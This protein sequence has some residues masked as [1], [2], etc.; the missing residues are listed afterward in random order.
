MNNSD[1]EINESSIERLRKRIII[2]ENVNL[3]SKALNDQEMIKWI[4]RQI[5]E[6]VQTLINQGKNE[7]I[8]DNNSS[9]K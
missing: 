8:T 7:Q 5:E 1:I 6:E 2:K 3:K 9:K 4:K